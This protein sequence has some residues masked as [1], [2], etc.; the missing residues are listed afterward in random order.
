MLP[1][2]MG[3]LDH[4]LFPVGPAHFFEEIWTKSPVVLRDNPSRFADLFDWAALDDY[5]NHR[6]R[7]FAFPAI[8]LYFGAERGGARVP[9]ELFTESIRDANRS[10]MSVVSPDSVRTLCREGATLLVHSVHDGHPKLK[11]FA[12]AL[13]H[14]LGETLR[15]DLFYTPPKSAG[16]HAHFDREDVFVLQ[17]EGQKEWHLSKP[18]VPF[19]LRMPDYAELDAAPSAPDVVHRLSR[20]DVMHIP[21]GFWHATHTS[22][23]PS[24]HLSVRVACR[25]GVDLLRWAVDA[26]E[27]S[28]PSVRK[29]LPLTLQKGA[30]YGYDQA[31]LAP[32]L[33]ALRDEVVDLLDSPDLLARFNRACIKGDR[34][35]EPYQFAAAALAQTERTH[36]VRPAIQRSALAERPGGD[37]YTLV[38]WGR[39]VDFSHQELPIL[40]AVLANT[41]FTG[42]QLVAS[43][44]GAVWK[45]VEPVVS[46]LV[47][48]GLLF[49]DVA[50]DQANE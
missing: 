47:A 18:T 15:I 8:Q 26:L 43:C 13:Q 24:L 35:P 1:H 2:P 48:E 12:A 44:S 39:E 3:V 33:R 20:G 19:P 23:A 41:R 22:T 28:V 16:V 5:L 30:P 34:A 10:P 27:A 49:V 45:D 25:T 11:E 46:R 7:F 42:T 50:G 38:A 4:L 14:E 37:G 32:S 6:L 29:N 36:F 9:H 21:R 17:L 40:R 31:S